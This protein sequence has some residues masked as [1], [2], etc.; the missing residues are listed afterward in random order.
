LTRDVQKVRR[1]RGLIPQIK[2]TG[3]SMKEGKEKTKPRGWVHEG[4]KSTVEQGSMGKEGKRGR[5]N[6]GEETLQLGNGYLTKVEEG[7]IGPTS[8]LA[9][10]G[11]EEYTQVRKRGT[12]HGEPKLKGETSIGLRTSN[13]GRWHAKV[14]LEK[15]RSAKSDR[16]LGKK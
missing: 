16:N 11:E 15:A 13:S 10:W 1:S 9:C 4:D 12:I 5:K 3:S 14:T 6:W 7:V 2:S 8:R